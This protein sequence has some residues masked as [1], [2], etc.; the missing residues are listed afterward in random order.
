MRWLALVAF[1]GAGCLD[2]L[3]PD[4]NKEAA[5]AMTPQ[6]DLLPPPQD[7]QDPQQP[8]SSDDGG[9]AGDMAQAAASGDLATAP[10]AGLP[11]GASCAVA[12]DCQSGYCEN[13]MMALVCTVPCTMKGMNDPACPN[14]GM[15]NQNGFCK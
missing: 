7:P 2:Q 15:C 13:V 9:A 11:F 8:A 6:P 3:L 12:T 14:A 5:T 4:R 1:L 10:A